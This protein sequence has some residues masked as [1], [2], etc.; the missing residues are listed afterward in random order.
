MHS[1]S[2]RHFTLGLAAASAL[3]AAGGAAIG[4]RPGE[5]TI[6]IGG[7]PAGA[8]A[9]LALRAAHPTARVLLVER[10]PGRLAR[11]AEDAAAAAFTRP[12]AE[13]SL[14]A[15]KAAGIDVVLDDVVEIDWAAA[16]LA[17]FSNRQLA[18]D[19]LLLA[20]GTGPR[21]EAIP[22]LDA[23]ARHAWPAAW[24]STR[25]A[26]RL[27][28]QLAALPERGHVVLRLPAGEIGHPQAAVARAVGLARHLAAAR[29]AGR[30]TVL[31]GSADD[32]LARAF[33]E[34]APRGPAAGVTWLTAAEGGI[35]RAVDARQG[36]IETDAGRLRADVVNFVPPLRAGE[37]ARTAG[38]VDATGWCPCDARGRSSLRDGV[39][40]LG[41]ARKSAL[42]TVAGAVQSAQA[43]TR[44]I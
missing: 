21:D 33:A 17:L 12:R 37:I 25:E 13:A 10:D 36:L 40:V 31:D 32:R 14:E 6:V 27:A 34:A 22:G 5:R 44:G 20:P 1:L 7:G 24:G 9:A 15:L 26:R 29:P 3:A 38:L 23:V 8:G 11:E 4:L 39:L 2:R 28:A 42:R 19:R 43:A 41:D 16:R 30:L 35:V 18:F